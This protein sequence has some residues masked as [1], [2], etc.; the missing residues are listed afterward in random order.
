MR[1][2]FWETTPAR[3]DPKRDADFVLTRVLEFGRLED[4][5]W[6][7]KQYGLARI[8]RFFRTVASPEISKR[9]LSFWRAALH[10]E[11]ESWPTPSAFRQSSRAYWV[12]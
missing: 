6:L 8:H 5:R 7:V 4:V 1:W 2:L 9:T 10:A 12:R 3:I 11:N